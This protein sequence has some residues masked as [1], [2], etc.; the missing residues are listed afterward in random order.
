MEEILKKEFIE[1]IVT[2]IAENVHPHKIIVFGS[3][4]YGKPH[5]EN[6]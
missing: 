4:A 3:Y 2:K 1:E 6:P 5:K